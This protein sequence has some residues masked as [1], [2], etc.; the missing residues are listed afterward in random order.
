MLEDHRAKDVPAHAAWLDAVEQQ[1]DPTHVQAYTE[2]QWRAWCAEAG[3]TVEHTETYAKV[4]DFLDW[5]S[6]QAMDDAAVDALH[7]AFL[8]GPEGV[9]G[10]FQFTMDGDRIVRWVDDKLLLRA[11]RPAPTS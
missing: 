2:D 11:R 10:A 4:H 3:L 8:R 9:P 6:R 1:R 5:C 7:E